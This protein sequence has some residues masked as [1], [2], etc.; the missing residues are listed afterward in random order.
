MTDT[1]HKRFDIEVG[2]EEAKR[3]F[4]HRVHNLI[5]DEWYWNAIQFI[6]RDVV[7]KYIAARLGDAYSS[8]YFSALHGSGDFLK[9]LNAI[10]AMRD[11]VAGRPTYGPQ[12]ARHLDGVV[13]EILDMSE[14][15]LG[16]TYAA[17]R[18]QRKGAALLDQRLVNDSLHW[19]AAKGYESVLTPYR[20]GLEHLLRSS[21]QRQ[22]GADVITDM[23]EAVEA[24]AKIV[25]RNDADLSA[26]RE[27]FISEVKASGPYKRLL[28][29]YI[30]YAN[31]FRHAGEEGKPKPQPSEREAESFV[32][33]T[34]V[35]IRLAMP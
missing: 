26:N 17:G 11:F 29:E 12:V 10:E 15:E 31:D 1:F 20:K 30:E 19:L 7:V 25:V 4:V 35:F 32:Y 24:L 27:R 5:F 8:T 22:V 13:Q 16:V 6:D 21:Q 9:N 3:R 28:K 18:F 34:G 2:L 33:L 23:Y 14:V